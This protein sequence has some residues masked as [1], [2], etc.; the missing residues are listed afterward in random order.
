MND[1]FT[2][3][4]ASRI[5]VKSL[6]LIGCATF[7]DTAG[8]PCISGSAAAGYRFGSKFAEVRLYGQRVRSVLD[9]ACRGT[10]WTTRA[11]RG[12]GRSSPHSAPQ[13]PSSV[14]HRDFGGCGDS[15]PLVEGSPAVSN[16]DAHPASGVRLSQGR[17]AMYTG[18][19]RHPKENLP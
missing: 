15:G 13:R 18:K 1:S 14:A 8:E 11:D 6:S 12:P 4:A 17:V 2:M 16:A 5:L 19:R 10:R 7:C 9:R 3:V